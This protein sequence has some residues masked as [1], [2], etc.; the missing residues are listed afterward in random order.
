MCPAT[1]IPRGYSVQNQAATCLADRCRRRLHAVW[2]AGLARS[3][4]PELARGPAQPTTQRAPT[5]TATACQ[6]RQRHLASHAWEA[7]CDWPVARVDHQHGGRSCGTDH[8]GRSGGRTM[9]PLP[10]SKRREHPPSHD[11][12]SGHRT[13]ELVIPTQRT[14]LPRAARSCQRLSRQSATEPLDHRG[15]D[16]TQTPPPALCVLAVA[17]ATRVNDVHATNH[18]TPVRSAI[19]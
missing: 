16:L 18:A 15:D 3:N 14:D 8:G 13:I 9:D 11:I 17:L 5:V 2:C 10:G 1:T 19:I 12:R 6:A 4:H 7:W